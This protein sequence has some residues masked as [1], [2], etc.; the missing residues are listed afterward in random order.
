M[1]RHEHMTVLYFPEDGQPRVETLV[2]DTIEALNVLVDGYVRYVNL[3]DGLTLAVNEDGM[4]LEM[5][6]NRVVP[7]ALSGWY[8]PWRSTILGPFVIMRDEEDLSKEDIR[9]IVHAFGETLAAE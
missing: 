4:H 3:K 2:G 8:D 6:P 5:A 1:A 9:R 7:P